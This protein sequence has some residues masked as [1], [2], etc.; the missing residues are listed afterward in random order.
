MRDPIALLLTTAPVPPNIAMVPHGVAYA[1]LES[2]VYCDMLFIESSADDRDGAVE[3][4]TEFGN[5][6][7]N[8]DPR[9]T[10]YFDLC[11]IAMTTVDKEHVRE[12][13]IARGWQIDGTRGAHE[14]LRWL[15]SWS[16][17]R[18]AD[19]FGADS[20]GARWRLERPIIEPAQDVSDNSYD[21]SST[22]EE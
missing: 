14:P 3:A 17:R 22:E 6:V 2:A 4:L 11:K 7:V 5:I 12:R 10:F 16:P 1:V 19:T 20:S 9:I 18:N 8:Q 13:A 21:S 15:V